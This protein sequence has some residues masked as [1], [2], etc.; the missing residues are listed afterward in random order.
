MARLRA[1]V[2]LV[3]VAVAALAMSACS[4][5]GGKQAQQGAVDVGP[6][7]TIAMITHAAPGDSFWDIIRKGAEAAAA[8]DNVTLLYFS[9]P[10]VDKQA[11]LVQQAID[12]RVDGIALTLSNPT[13]MKDAVSKAKAAG[14]PVISFNAGE[15]QSA[16]LGALAHIGEDESLAGE[17]VGRTLAQSGSK[18]AICV[19]QQQG[20]VQLEDRCS[21]TERTFTG[22][23]SERLY[24]N[25]EDKS[26]VQQLITSKLQSDKSVDTVIALGTP[27]AQ[28]ALLSV[29]DSG[30]KAKVGTYGL[31]QQ[32]VQS[33]KDNKLIW[34]VDQQPFLQ[35]Y[36][37]VDQLWLYK[38]NGNVMGV[39]QQSQLTGPTLITPQNVSQIE[40]FAKQGTR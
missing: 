30:S 32:T 28:V 9:A 7:R 26:Q 35:G 2:M 17:V 19:I 11:Q 14:I 31:D 38:K 6:H 27:I 34:A 29:A 12:Q 36:E 8:K 37:S 5:G 4:S 23:Q 16:Q 22:G 1:S 25:G 40:E 39:G 21:G 10:E 20:Q 13:G 18:K 3:V 33:L 15:K 24:V